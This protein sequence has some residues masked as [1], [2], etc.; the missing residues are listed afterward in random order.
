MKLIENYW[1]GFS[2][3]EDLTEIYKTRSITLRE[4][5]PFKLIEIDWHVMW[6]IR[7]FEI[8]IWV[9]ELIERKT[10]VNDNM[11][12]WLKLIEK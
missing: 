3:V 5:K 7:L 8:K 4:T 6:N 2:F 10:E 9:L 11:L 1:E 12:N